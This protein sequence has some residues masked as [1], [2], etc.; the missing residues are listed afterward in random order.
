MSSQRQ[1]FKVARC[2][3]E[4]P[5]PLCKQIQQN[6]FTYCFGVRGGSCLVLS[7]LRINLN[8]ASRDQEQPKLE[9]HLLLP[10][11]SAGRSLREFNGCGKGPRDPEAWDRWR[12]WA[13]GPLLMNG[14][15]QTVTDTRTRVRLLHL[16]QEL[17]C[18]WAPGHTHILT[19][20]WFELVWGK[21]S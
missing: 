1:L 12:V 4:T 2:R 19:N 7:F 5:A 17:L 10:G 11:T 16:S 8:S 18:E 15:C 3:C 20:R 14:S 9:C 21:I 13:L 6:I